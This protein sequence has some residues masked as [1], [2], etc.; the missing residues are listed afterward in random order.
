MEVYP[1]PSSFCGFVPTIVFC[2]LVK[3]LRL[4]GLCGT[5]ISPPDRLSVR[6]VAIPFSRPTLIR[7]AAPLRLL[8]SG[9]FISLF[10]FFFFHYGF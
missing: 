2:A 4:V 9:T 5:F 10:S 8:V 3:Y 7:Q 6:F 1:S